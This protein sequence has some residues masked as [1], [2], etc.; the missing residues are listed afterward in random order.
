[1]RLPSRARLVPTL[2]LLAAWACSDSSTAPVAP[3]NLDG[4]LAEMSLSAL[5]PGANSI[6]SPV[7]LGSVSPASCAYNGAVQSYNTTIRTF[8][9]AIGAKIFYGAKPMVPYEAAT[10]GAEVAPSLEGKL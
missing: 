9:D 7:P 6:G 1:M 4:A 3:P 5:V 2:A 8:P 10:P